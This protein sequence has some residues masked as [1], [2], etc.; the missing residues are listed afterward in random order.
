MTVKIEK[1]LLADGKSIRWRAR[2]VSTGKDPVT[3]KRR[4]RTITGRTQGEVEREVRK[5]GVAV[6]KGT[7]T[8]PW[9]GTI[10]EM[11]DSWL[12]A[13]T[14]GKELNTVV[15][16]RLALRVP[17]E[18][19]GHRRALS[20]T[21]DDVESLVD[22]ALTEGRM[23]GG[24]PGTGLSVTT[25]RAMLDRLSSAFEQAVDDG[26][27]PRN[28]CRKVRVTGPAR[29]PRSTWNESEVQRFI[30]AVSGERLAACWLLSLLGLRRGE[31][32]GLRWSD[33]SF[34]DAALSIKTTHVTVNGSVLEK[35]P[36]STRGYRTLPLFEPV[37]GALL[38]LYETQLAEARAA[39]PAYAGAVDEGFVCADELGQPVHPKAWSHSFGLLCKAASLPKIRLHD[40]RHS[41]NSLLEHL[42]VSDSIRA[43]WFG[44]SIQVNRTTYTHSQQEDLAAVRT[45]LGGLF[46][47]AV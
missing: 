6:D 15:C 41:V 39:G 8:K 21:R 17:R 11:C 23:R 31:V 43:A 44:H 30:A 35:G 20:V 40:C 46:S 18:R 34:T 26:K 42:G 16:Y 4:Q 19:L 9:D 5:I 24:K 2:G 10:N 47:K 36:K 32:T 3:G 38:A 14:R 7:Y 33:I 29:A 45:A 12:R 1:V 28:P 37:L 27:L 13:A 25:V 22:Y